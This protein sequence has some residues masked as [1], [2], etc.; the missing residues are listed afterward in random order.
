MSPPKTAGSFL[1]DNRYQQDSQAKS[2]DSEESLSV[3]P[4][5]EPIFF[6]ELLASGHD[7]PVIARVKAFGLGEARENN[8]GILAQTFFVGREDIENV[9]SNPDVL[10][11]IPILGTFVM[12]ATRGDNKTSKLDEMTQLILD[13]NSALSVGMISSPEVVRRIENG[14]EFYT[15]ELGLGYLAVKYN[16]SQ[17]MQ[18][19][20]TAIDKIRESIS[21]DFVSS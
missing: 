6:G 14:E 9:L 13:N 2:S 20:H 11:T 18:A 1:P 16:F 12:D 15:T 8:S 19:A 5:I 10:K 3:S 21:Q 4:E 7:V 17:E